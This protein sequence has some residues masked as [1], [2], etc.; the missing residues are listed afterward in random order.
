LKLV[1]G[2]SP[3]PVAKLK[4]RLKEKQMAIYFVSNELPQKMAN[5]YLF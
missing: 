5:K 1:F 4:F 3:H 2:H